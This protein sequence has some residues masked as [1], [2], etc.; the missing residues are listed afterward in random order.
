MAE[1]EAG[2]GSSPCFAHLLVDG[3]PVD[4]D[5]ARDVARFRRA[6]RARLVAERALSSGDRRGATAALIDRL[7]KVIAPGPG[8]TVAGYWPIRGEPDLRSWMN[9]VHAAGAQV[10]LPVV[11]EEH[12]PLEFHSWSPSCR[13]TRGFWNIPVPAGGRAGRPDVVIAP[14][15][16]ADE[17][18]YRLGNGGGYYDRTLPRIDPPPRVIGVGFA[19]CLLPTIFPMPWDVPMDDVILSD[20]AHLHR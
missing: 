11:V 15:V 6:E 2:H 3:H 18:L 5:T 4:P 13:M 8:M 7:E 9:K 10:L 20:G 12:A 19:G 14:L 17:A 16:G 1:D